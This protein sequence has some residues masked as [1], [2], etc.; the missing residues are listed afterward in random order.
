MTSQSAVPYRGQ[1]KMDNYKANVILCPKSDTE[2]E[3]QIQ[4]RSLREAINSLPHE[5]VLVKVQAAGICH[6]D[7]HLWKGHYKVIL[8]TG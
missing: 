6:S 7:V 8:A 1:V 5:G 2:K 3:L 4:T